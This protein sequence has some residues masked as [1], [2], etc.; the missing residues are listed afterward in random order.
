MISKLHLYKKKTCY[1][2]YSRVNTLPY[3]LSGTSSPTG[4]EI[5]F[6]NFNYFLSSR[7]TVITDWIKNLN[8]P[9]FQRKTRTV[10]KVSDLTGSKG[11][12]LGHSQNK[13]FPVALLKTYEKK[14]FWNK[15][16]SSLLNIT[17]SRPCALTTFLVT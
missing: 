1:S 3:S 7:N 8:I 2:E 11:V 14:L 9:L 15:Q 4:C 17:F 13:F 5:I 10:R 6:L 12:A 16:T